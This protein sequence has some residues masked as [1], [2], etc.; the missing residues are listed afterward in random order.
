MH[1]I[2]LYYVVMDAHPEGNTII[3]TSSCIMSDLGYHPHHHHHI[4]D[5]IRMARCL[6]T[7][8]AH[9]EV[10]MRSMYYIITIIMHTMYGTQMVLCSSMHTCIHVP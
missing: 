3:T 7:P 2:I 9:H 6:I 4:M 10:L 1:T 8:S 5:G